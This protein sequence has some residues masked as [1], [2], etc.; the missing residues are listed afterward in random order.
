MIECT[1]QKMREHGNLVPQES[2]ERMKYGR[3]MHSA[4]PV[5][6]IEK[7][8][9]VVGV[10]IDIPEYETHRSEKS[11][12]EVAKECI[13]F[14]NTPPQNKR[15][16]RRIKPLYA[17]FEETPYRIYEK[18]NEQGETFLQAL[19]VVSDRRNKSFWS[20]GEQTFSSKEDKKAL[21]K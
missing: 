15:G 11:V 18:K 1:L 14:L 13:E 5:K 9:W 6:G 4:F 3:Y 20:N 7:R 16:R 2:K 19:L 21:D 8:R 10:H 12:E 17:K